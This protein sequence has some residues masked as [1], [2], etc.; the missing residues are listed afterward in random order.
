MTP[1]LLAFAGSLRVDSFNK[2]LVKIAAG[3]ARAA[4]ADVTF[5]DLRDLPLP[6]YDED[7]EKSAGL[8]PNAR[9]LKDLLLTHHGLLIASPE[10]NSAL[11]AVLKNAI[12]WA[13]RPA[14]NE[15]PL[16]CFAG[17]TAGIMA[18][19]PG[20]LGGLRGLVSLRSLLGNI[21]VLVLPDQFALVKAHEAFNADGT[22]KDAAQKTTVENI[23]AAVA[24]TV[25]KLQ[26]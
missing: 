7:L 16:E 24:Q 26:A 14:P 2:K 19:S 20:A 3:G 8:P 10:Y 22:L 6:L 5:L 1:K 25:A 4:G 17:K 23:G 13:S 15:K 9:K 11:S 21:R 12:D 18:A